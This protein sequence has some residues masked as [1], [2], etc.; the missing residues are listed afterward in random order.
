[1]LARRLAAYAEQGGQA[2]PSVTHF[3]LRSNPDYR[4]DIR[5]DARVK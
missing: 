1:V 4:K 3:F 2:S 5:I